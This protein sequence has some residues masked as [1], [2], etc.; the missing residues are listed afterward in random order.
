MKK[1]KHFIES[2]TGI[3][4]ETNSTLQIEDGAR[5]AVMGGGPAGSF[6]SYFFLANAARMGMDTSLDIYEKRDFLSFG[7]AGCNM[8]GGIISE[9]LVQTLAA[10]GIN[11]PPT[12]VERGIDSYV[13][14]MDEG[15]VRIDTP[16]RE[17]RIAAVHR[18]A[19]PKG[20]KESK[21]FSFDEHLLKL[22]V[23]SGAN[24]KRDQVVGI[25]FV[26]NKPQ[27]KTKNGSSH[28]YDL[29]VVATGVN[30]PSLKIF[31]KLPLF[32]KPPVTSKT[33]ICEFNLG[34]SRVEKF[35]GSSMHVFLLHIPRL[36][37]A[38]LI[39][40]GDFITICLLGK[41]ID[42]QLV[43]SFINSEQVKKC[44]P[45]DWKFPEEF[46]HCS[47]KINIKTAEK[48]FADRI[49]FIGDAGTSRLYKDG[50]GAAYKTAKAAATTAVFKGISSD[51]FEKHFYPTCKSIEWDNR[52][53]KFI[54]SITRM[55]QKRAHDRRGILRMVYRE[56]NRKKISLRM[57]TVLWDTFTGSAPYREILL[58]T[59]HPVYLFNLIK[60]VILGIFLFDKNKFK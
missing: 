21:W 14:H 24:L 11:L 3:L 58:R 48:P 34:Q 22:A 2:F 5:I 37:F 45:P 53:G 54:F 18:G 9:S 33:Y 7:P 30:T 57:S 32:Y 25:E 26:D 40:K 13:M 17:K 1:K 51:C 52:L 49:V 50:I 12:V 6:F 47:P 10:E 56:Q 43:K 36:E 60:E 15:S 59:L 20:I 8:C 38:A 42:D 39:P 28:V 29:L 55:I 16:L 35:L 27:L 44:L 41:D 31:E 46:C 23:N 19:G 4:R